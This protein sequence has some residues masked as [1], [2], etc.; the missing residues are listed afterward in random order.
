VKSYVKQKEAENLR[1]KS[2]RIGIQGLW[3]IKCMVI[4]VIFGAIGIVTKVLKK[5]L[6]AVPRTNSIDSLQ[7]AAVLGTSDVIREVLQSGT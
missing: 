5:N 7:K 6:E 2:L 4:P 1:Y 3:N